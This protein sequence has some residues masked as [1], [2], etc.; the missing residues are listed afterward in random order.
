MERKI[1]K[2]KH[3]PI[4]VAQFDSLP[5]HHFLLH[6]GSFEVVEDGKEGEVYKF[7]KYLVNAGDANPIVNQ[8]GKGTK[9]YF[10]Y[11]LRT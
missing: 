6:S 5:Q 10:K 3:Q 8:F 9:I 1:R 11:D 4:D 7:T 2:T